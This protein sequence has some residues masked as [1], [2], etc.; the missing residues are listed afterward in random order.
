MQEKYEFLFKERYGQETSP[1]L[2]EPDFQL[3]DACEEVSAGKK[4][5][6]R[7]AFGTV[8]NSDIFAAPRTNSGPSSS[9]AGTHA[10]L[11]AEVA[12]R[13]A[14][15][16]EMEELKAK[17]LQQEEWLKRIQQQLNQQT[18]LGSTTLPCVLPHPSSQF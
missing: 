11:E 17:S 10:L 12:W 13:T 1:E 7:L 5:G 15:E 4:K 9:D 18:E 14:L 16:R 8:G 2:F 3:W 6:R